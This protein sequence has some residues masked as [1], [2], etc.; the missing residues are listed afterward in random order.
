MGLR[1]DLDFGLSNAD[2]DYLAR[3]QEIHLRP[4]SPPV[5]SPKKAEADGWA[6]GRRHDGHFEKR[7][8]TAYKHMGDYASPALHVALMGFR[9][10][11]AQ[12]PAVLPEP[13]RPFLKTMTPHFAVQ[14]PGR[15]L[16]VG[17]ETMTRSL[18]RL[19][20]APMTAA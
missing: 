15:V 18:G 19:T 4:D 14:P 12:A 20:F 11:Q 5:T 8:E 9:S 16:E 10:A 2:P 17:K 1:F 7:Y 3:L 13:G 6:A